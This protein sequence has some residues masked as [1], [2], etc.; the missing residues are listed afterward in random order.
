MGKG[1]LR[2]AMPQT[3][4][5]IDDLRRV[6]GQ[7]YIDGILRRSMA[8]ETDCFFAEENG[9]SFGTRFTPSGEGLTWSDRLGGLVSMDTWKR[10][11]QDERK[12]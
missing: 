12:G 1:S 10:E 7:V 8:G 9:K 3:A 5:F 11:Q 4:R 2:D 6:F